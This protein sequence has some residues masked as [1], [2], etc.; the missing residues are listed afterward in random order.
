MIKRLRL[1]MFHFILLL[2]VGFGALADTLLQDSNLYLDNTLPSDSL[3]NGDESGS[4]QLVDG[5]TLSTYNIQEGEL[6][7]VPWFINVHI[8]MIL[9]TFISPSKLNPMDLSC[10]TVPILNSTLTPLVITSG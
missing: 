4:N 3:F 5:D 8:M 10:L 9:L 1:Y 2:V 7:T 6:D